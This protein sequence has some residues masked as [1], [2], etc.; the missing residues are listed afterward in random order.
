M[1]QASSPIEVALLN[2]RQKRRAGQGREA[3]RLYV[4]AAEL[5]RLEGDQTALAHALRHAS[6][7]ARER[8]ASSKAWRDASEAAALYRQTGDKLGLANALR[9]Q[10]LS[11]ADPKTGRACWEEAHDLYSRLGVDAGVAECKSRLK[12]AN[13]PE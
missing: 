11:A 8:G 7:L 3:E 5:A 6:D 12:G 10:A 13:Q 4:E 1:P 9:L 2:A